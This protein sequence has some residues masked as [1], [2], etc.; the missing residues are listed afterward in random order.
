MIQKPPL[1]SR[2][3]NAAKIALVIITVLAL[4]SFPY[5]PHKTLNIYPGTNVWW[6]AF[7]ESGGT[8]FEYQNESHSALECIMAGTG[9]FNMCGNS[10]VFLDNTTVT[11]DKLLSDLAFAT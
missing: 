4:F 1:L 2:H 9:S 11:H 10:C 8:L 3:L 6:G 7:T 5:I